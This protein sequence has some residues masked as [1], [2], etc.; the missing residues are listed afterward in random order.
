M[1]TPELRAAVD[2]LRHTLSGIVLDNHER[3]AWQT[4]LSALAEMEKDAA[5]MDWMEQRKRCLMS[6]TTGWTVEFEQQ[7]YHEY[8]TAR[9]AIDAAIAAADA[10]D[11]EGKT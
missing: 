10:A 1:N 9:A 6:L 8:K 11:R 7:D 5:R 3:K 4:V 2:Q